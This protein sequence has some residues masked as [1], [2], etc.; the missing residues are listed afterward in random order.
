MANRWLRLLSC[1][2]LAFGAISCHSEPPVEAAQPLT[3][4]VWS[5]AVTPT[6]VRVNAKILK[7]S[8]KV[9]LLV[10]PRKDLG[11]AIA[12]P[13]VSA[14]ASNNRVV[15]IP[16]GGLTP[17]TEYHYAIEVDGKADLDRRGEFHTFKDGPFSFSLAFASCAETGSNH[18]VFETIREREPLFFLHM[19]DFHYED[20]AD[21]QPAIR[22]AYERVLASPRQSE[23]YRSVPIAYMWDDHDFGGNNADSTSNSRPAVRRVYRQ[24]VPHYPL[25]AGNGNGPIYQAWT[26]GRVRFLL[27]DLR[28]ERSPDSRADGPAKTMMGA[29]QKAWLKRE[30]LAAQKAGQLIVW[31]ST[32]PWIEAPAPGSDGWGGFSTE[33]RELANFFKQNG[34]SR[35]V[36]LSGDAHMLALDDGTH[37]GYA[38][39]GGGAFPL[40]HAAALDRTGSRKGGPYSHGAF[41]SRTKFRTHDGQFGWMEVKDKGGPEICIDWK[42]YRQ[43][44]DTATV[45]ELLSYSRCFAAPPKP[46]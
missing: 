5:G 3:Q 24:Y 25:A 26:V 33:R 27:T 22:T 32:P 19:G 15:S 8:Q 43:E 21:D 4:F 45:K 7:D 42:G 31:V 17:D 41:P 20:R 14:S 10:S 23:L 13:F 46:K 30:M 16:L 6:S 44:L 29:A 36:M 38:A 37:S 35:L 9:R 12:S 18:R 28:S 39:G 34:I 40:M 2:L 1:L 11:G